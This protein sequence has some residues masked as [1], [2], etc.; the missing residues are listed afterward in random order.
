M[1][2]VD[3]LSLIFIDFYAPALTPRDNSKETSLQLSENISLFA[4]CRI[5]TGVINKETWIVIRCLGRIIYIYT[6]W[7]TGR[8]LVAPLL[9]YP[10][11]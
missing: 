5:Y 3:G 7:G 9:S 8:N 11:A 1:R 4:V 10:L 2:K 6:I